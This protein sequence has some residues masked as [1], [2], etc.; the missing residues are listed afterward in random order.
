[1]RNDAHDELDH[2]P[3]LKADQR[4]H[5]D[6]DTD[7]PEPARAPAYGRAAASAA[8]VK[9]A[10]TGPLWALVG[11][12]MIALGG[13][14]WWSFQQISLME[15]Q[16]VAT[17]ESFARISE[18]AAGRIQDITGKVVATESN[19]TSGS[20]ALKLQV[21]QLEGKLAELGKQQQGIASQQGEQTKRLEQLSAD[22]KSQEGAA[23]K[24]E[25]PL[26]T[27]G[28][29]QASLKAELATLKTAQ[30]GLGKVEEQ[31]KRLGTDVDALKKIGNPNQAIS[32]LEQDLLVLKSDLETRPAPSSNTAEFDAFRAQM[33]RNIST[34][35]A[36]VQ[37]LQ[38]QIDAR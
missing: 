15:Q 17:Q 5:S 35:Q 6:Y 37:N 20:E 25:G 1:M 24:F 26:K 8:P 7:H 32:R 23:S 16:L 34:L 29:E 14:G 10:S 2:V 28:T 11:A 27:L 12:L 22:L 31:L 9:G 21:K 4:D 3:S 33:T 19:V 36:Q 18:E 30:G 38:Q 13:L